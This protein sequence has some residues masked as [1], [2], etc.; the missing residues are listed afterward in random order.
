MAVK[1]VSGGK[2]GQNLPWLQVSAPHT[3]T[4]TWGS[5]Q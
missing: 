1:E 4:K 2:R 3:K 5:G